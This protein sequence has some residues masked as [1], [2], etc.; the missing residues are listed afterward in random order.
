MNIL[1][2][3]VAFKKIEIAERKS[4]VPANALE[5]RPF[6]QFRR[7]SLKDSIRKPDSTGIIAEFKRKSPSKGII[8]DHADV[9][10]TTSAYCR[11]GVSGLSVLT[12]SN[13]FGGSD[14]D[15]IQAREV[16][17]IPILRKDF[18]V[19]EYQI[20]E[21]KSIGADVILLIAA[22]L[23]PKNLVELA[24][25]AKQMELEVLMEVHSL[26]ELENNLSDQID[27]IGVNNRNL[28]T[29]QT[30]IA[31]SLELADHI[32]S[33]FVKI[34][35]SGISNPSTIIELSQ[36]G[37]EGFLIGENFMATNDPGKACAQFINDIESVKSSNSSLKS[38][39]QGRNV[40]QNKVS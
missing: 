14:A 10:V 30:S 34:S 19:D 6:F 36:A 29:F 16:N 27:L 40:S 11:S 32:P 17:D 20:I 39:S 33:D 25:F 9:R 13:Y 35:E 5:N 15:L 2:E 8:N 1:E 21:A 24:T 4:N 28:K 37:F 3:I 23:D 38:S 22:A 26:K 7:R 18:I 12:D 31:T